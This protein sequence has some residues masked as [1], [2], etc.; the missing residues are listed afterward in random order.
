MLQPYQEYGAV[1]LVVI[2]A[3]KISRLGDFAVQGGGQQ[4]YPVVA[5]LASQNPSKKTQQLVCQQRKT[6]RAP[7]SHV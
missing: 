2:E 5:N 7:C 4:L 6:G 3:L 1:T